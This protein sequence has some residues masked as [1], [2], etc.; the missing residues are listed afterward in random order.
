[1]WMSIYVCQIGLL[2]SLKDAWSF[3]P[4]NQ[5]GNSEVLLTV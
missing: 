5:N 2:G 1:M 4:N 3:S